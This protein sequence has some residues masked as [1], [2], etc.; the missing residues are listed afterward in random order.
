[1]KNIEKTVLETIQLILKNHPNLIPDVETIVR[2][3]KEGLANTSKPAAEFAN[4][5]E[6]IFTMVFETNMWADEESVSGS[7]STMRYTENLRKH[8]PI[9]FRDLGIKSIFDAPCGDFNWM[10]HV[11]KDYPLKYIG[12]DIVAPLVDKL[13]HEHGNSQTSFIHIDLTEQL[14]PEADIMMCRDCLF[15]LPYSD[16]RKIFANFV[17]SNIKYLFTTSHVTLAGFSNVDVHLGGFALMN[18]GL[19]PYNFPKTAIYRVED[20]IQGYPPREMVLWSRDQ[21]IEGL[22]NFVL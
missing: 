5:K 3:A 22:K 19:P 13:N 15:H 20:Y 6:G 11:L 10:R 4:R 17:D 9:I 2:V 12:G 14:F 8:M 18:L 16:A 7:G 1:M 21:V